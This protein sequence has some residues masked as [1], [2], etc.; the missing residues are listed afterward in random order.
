MHSMPIL[1]QWP[2]ASVSN[3]SGLSGFGPGWTRTEGPG[4][5]Q[6]PPSNPTRSVLAGLLPGSD[7]NPRFFG[8]VEPGPLF[9]ITVPPTFAPI[10]YLSS[11]RVTI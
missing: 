2:L 4:L 6:E 10:K 11:D 5:G 7:I 8:R 1:C 9:H 3:G